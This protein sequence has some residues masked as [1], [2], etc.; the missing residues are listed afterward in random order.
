MSYPPIQTRHPVL[1]VAVRAE[2]MVTVPVIA[3]WLG[4][5]ICLLMFSQGW[6]APLTGYKPNAADSAILRN[7][8]L[9]VYGVV[10]VML[11]ARA[12]DLPKLALREPLV[13]ALLG[14]AALSTLWSVDPSATTRRVVALAFTTLAGMAIAQRWSWRALAELIGT[15]FAF[16]GV[17]SFALGV[18]KPDWGRMSELFPG[19]WRG[20]WLEKNA[21]GGLMSVAALIQVV[22]A[23]YVPRRRLLWLGFAALS[24]GL[25]LLSQ[26]KTSLVSLVLGLG[27]I[28]ACWIAQRG[29]AIAIALVWG[30]VTLVAVA[31]AVL[32]IAPDLLFNLLGKDATLTGRT[33]LWAAA[34]HQLESHKW[35]GFGYGVVWDYKSDW[36]PG[37]WI[38]HDAHFKAGHAHNGW[39]ET[40]LSLG[41]VGLSVWVL[42]FLQVCGRAVKMF[43]T[44]PGA[45]LALPFLVV[46]TIR[47]ITE[48]EVLQYHNIEWT[49]FVLLATK[50][51]STRQEDFPN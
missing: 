26:S 37:A 51:A 10:I 16:W 3:A 39:L 6:E 7:A 30:S 49:L 45:L 28:F 19:A 24:L 2:P 31:A 44:S 14:L 17:I 42:Y 1:G 33:V 15:S 13:L 47:T 8:F 18:A 38:S 41:I 5:L 25:V 21:L 27:V 46:Y 11:A 29:P 22:A 50:M 36:S 9:P 4:S 34:L 43:F 48:S 12:G 40:A 35:L 20:V 32:V 23:I